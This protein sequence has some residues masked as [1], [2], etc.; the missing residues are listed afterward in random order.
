VKSS[1]SLKDL[2]PADSDDCFNAFRIVGVAG[3][4]PALN[5]FYDDAAYVGCSFGLCEVSVEVNQK[6]VTPR[7]SD[8]AAV[9]IGNSLDFVVVL[10]EVI[11]GAVSSFA[12]SDRQPVV[13]RF[14]HEC[15]EVASESGIG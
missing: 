13:T 3:R 8:L 14:D 10:A 7:L 11:R 12:Y 4:K 6:L 5:T 15:S 9:P 1:R 2:K